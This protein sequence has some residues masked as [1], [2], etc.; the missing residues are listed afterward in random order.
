MRRAGLLGAVLA[1]GVVVGA[2]N[3]RDPVSA[4]LAAGQL[5]AGKVNA[6]GP[7]VPIDD[8][9]VTPALAR[10]LVPGVRVNAILSSDDQLPGSPSF[11]FGGSAD[12]A[13]LLQNGDG[14]YTM[15]VNHEDN[16][17]V[18]RVTLDRSFRPT[19]GEYLLN[20]TVGRYRLCSATLATPEEHGFGPLFI[21]AGE[22]NQESQIHAV[23]PF[24]PVNQS[25][26]LTAF[27]RWNTENAVP[28]PKQ[29]YPGARSS[30]S[31]TTTPGRSAGRWRSTCPTRSA[32][33]RTAA[34]T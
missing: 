30:S 1:G 27:G 17:S 24:G 11:V 29:A 28:L 2:C 34:S 12:G 23:D 4:E 19:R 3:D 8:Y 9:S 14:T 31:A 33:W 32:T 25:T 13:G 22:S 7:G 5:A 26:L 18:S 21:T 6:G 20:S 16:F 15:L 10:A